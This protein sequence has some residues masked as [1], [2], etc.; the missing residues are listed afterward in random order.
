MPTGLLTL[1]P[2]AL[3][4]DLVDSPLDLFGGPI[5]MAIAFFLE[6]AFL[7]ALTG[8]PSRAL[9]YSGLDLVPGLDIIPFATLTLAKEIVKA[10]RAGPP[11]AEGPI[12]DA[13]VVRM[14][15]W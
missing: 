2:L 8:K 13:Q 15:P 6:A 11:A 5:S 12:I 9:L 1:V 14:S 10:W 3:F 4:L 7:L